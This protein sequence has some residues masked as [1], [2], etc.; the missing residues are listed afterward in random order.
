MATTCSSASHPGAPS[1]SKHASWGLTATQAGPAATTAARQCSTTAAAVRDRDRRGSS[2][3]EPP[4]RSSSPGQSAA[5]SGSSPSTTRLRRSSTS[6]ASRSAKCPVNPPTRPEAVPCL[7]RASDN[8]A[9]RGRGERAE[10]RP[11]ASENAAGRFEPRLA[12][13]DR[14]LQRAPRAEARNAARGDLYPLAGLGVDA[15][16]SAAFGDRELPEAGEVEDRKS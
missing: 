12:A 9:Q 14:G 4:R 5:G 16:A 6:A 2:D 11:S 7:F 8:Q 15:L 10:P 13:L 1:L 3:P